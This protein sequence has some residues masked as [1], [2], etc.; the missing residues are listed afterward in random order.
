MK[1]RTMIFILSALVACG[2]AFGQEDG[3]GTVLAGVAL[4]GAGAYGLS[5]AMD[6]AQDEADA[7]A[8][9]NPGMVCVSSAIEASP[10]KSVLGGMG[11]VA[12]GSAIW[13]GLGW[14]EYFAEPGISF[15]FMDSNAIGIRKEWK[16]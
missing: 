3:G 8:R 15:G 16:F 9:D 1:T 11:V 4:I 2:P 13:S 10:V 5:S 14:S 6:D 12:G 7:C